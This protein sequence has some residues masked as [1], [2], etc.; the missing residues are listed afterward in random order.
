ELKLHEGKSRVVDARE[1]SF[2]FLGFTF[3]R[4]RNFKTARVITLVKPSRKSEQQF[5][6]EVR[7]LTSRRSHSTPQQ[8]VLERVN[9]Y[10]RG[11]VNYFHV[12]NSTRVFARQRFFLEQRMRKYLQTGAGERPITRPADCGRV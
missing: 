2:D 6:D 4:K 11:W 8:E 9:R 3:E 1:G 5:R 7:G 12:H 10:V